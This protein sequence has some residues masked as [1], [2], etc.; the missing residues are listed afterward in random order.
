MANTLI[1]DTTSSEQHESNLRGLKDRYQIKNSDLDKTQRVAEYQLAMENAIKDSLHEGQLSAMYSGVD[2]KR[3][4]N[5]QTNAFSDDE[6]TKYYSEELQDLVSNVADM[7]RDQLGVQKIRM[8]TMIESLKTSDAREKDMLTKQF[9]ISSEYLE[10]EYARKNNLSERVQQTMYD[11]SQQYMDYEALYSGFFKGNPI[12]MLGWK[13]GKGLIQASKKRKDD[14]KELVSRD[15]HRQEMA[16]QTEKDKK[17]ML[18]ADAIREEEYAEAETYYSSNID[19]QKPTNTITRDSGID[20]VDDISMSGTLFSG[21]DNEKDPIFT[22][23]IDGFELPD[24]DLNVADKVR[25]I[26]DERKDRKIQR[27]YYQQ[28]QKWQEKLLK[29]VCPFANNPAKKGKGVSKFGIGGM[30]VTG[31]SGMGSGGANG[32]DSDDALTAGGVIGGAGALWKYKDKIKSMLIPDSEDGKIK[33]TPKVD[34]DEKPGFMKKIFTKRFAKYLGIGT[35]IAGGIGAGGTLLDEMSPDTQMPDRNKGYGETDKLDKSYEQKHRQE[36]V[37]QVSDDNI[38]AITTDVALSTGASMLP[39]LKA[40]PLLGAVLGGVGDA[41]LEYAEG[42]SAGSSMVAGGGAI[43]GGMSGMT[44]GATIGAVGGPIGIAI[45]GL[46]GS[47]VGGIAGSG[48]ATSFAGSSDK[49]KDANLINRNLEERGIIDINDILPGE[50]STIKSPEKLSD[51][52]MN[53]LQA[54]LYVDDFSDD[55]TQLIKETLELKQKN[56]V[57]LSK[58]SQNMMDRNNK[59]SLTGETMETSTDREAIDGML[60]KIGKAE[61]NNNYDAEWGGGKF[62]DRGNKKLTEMTM[63][64]VKA[65]QKEMLN[66]QKDMGK[67]AGQRSSA[68]G[69][70]QFIS[71]S[72]KE[73]QLMSGLS[74]DDLYSEENQDKMGEMWLKKRGGMD[75]FMKSNKTN[76]DADKFQNKVATQ[77]ASMKN[78]QGRGAYDGDG[79]NTARHSVRDEINQLVSNNEVKNNSLLAMNEKSNVSDKL[80]GDLT[81][82]AETVDNIQ[83]TK[84]ELVAQNE[85]KSQ[86]PVVISQQVSNNSSGGNA[87]IGSSQVGSARNTDSSLQR[88]TDRYISTSMS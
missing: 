30:G 29:C 49:E 53:E 2:P 81:T 78:T 62:G 75:K 18:H 12:A 34:V 46:I 31:S 1:S 8:N 45:G 67:N 48:I 64:E 20:D 40:I 66:T 58:E 47:I 72:M 28:T 41:G 32:F 35:A 86:Q 4:K 76:Q 79:M 43:A 84:N 24:D 56:R 65:Y 11:M 26:E 61:S 42:G 9:A 77:W 55:D 54:L 70:Y 13:L 80:R 69:K 73:A 33:K 15:V 16:I 25:G 52:S 6:L 50:S 14:E 88:I 68:L 39:M 74:D 27:K 82:N 17:N 44:A 23:S 87:P 37:K 83:N 36:I 71:G 59:K 63:G 60:D 7:T 5:Q 38:T 10:K 21:G 3:V 22:K 85:E 19:K 57:K 51:L